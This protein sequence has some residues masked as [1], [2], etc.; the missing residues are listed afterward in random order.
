M[1]VRLGRN[2]CG[3]HQNGR[4]LLCP[5]HIDEN[6]FMNSCTRS[7][8]NYNYNKKILPSPMLCLFV[9]IFKIKL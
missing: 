7:K 6:R 4:F 5:P 9:D 3:R 8:L 2:E 1:I